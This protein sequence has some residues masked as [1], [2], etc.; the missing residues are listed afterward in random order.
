MDGNVSL[1][2]GFLENSLGETGGEKRET[3]QQ[4]G[5]WT[6]RS[7]LEWGEQ[8]KD[9][10]VCQNGPVSGLCSRAKNLPLDGGLD[11]AV[12]VDA[13]LSPRTRA[14]R[15]ILLAI[16]LPGLVPWRGKRLWPA[17][18]DG[19]QARSL[20]RC[21]EEPLL[22]AC[23][24]GGALGQGGFAV[25][26]PAKGPPRIREPSPPAP[27]CRAARYNLLS[28]RLCIPSASI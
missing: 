22:S 11:G 12:G 21:G 4:T 5:G 24:C 25:P 13:G 10:C 7:P 3:W 16:L 17:R 1:F 6:Q 19:G 26:L 8:R 9:G 14:G 15:S 18:G 28:T 2:F 20:G 23:W 27:C